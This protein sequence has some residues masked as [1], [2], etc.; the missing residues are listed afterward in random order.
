MYDK[1]IQWAGSSTCNLA[2]SVGDVLEPA[3]ACTGGQ[4]LNMGLVVL[5]IAAFGV[6]VMVI[7][8]CRRQRRENH[9]R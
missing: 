7:N 4:A 3:Q 2:V 1:L 6:V 8:A 5:G 9:F